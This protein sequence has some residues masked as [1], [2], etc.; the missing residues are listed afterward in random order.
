MAR[1]IGSYSDGQYSIGE[2]DRSAVVRIL[3]LV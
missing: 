2:R 3:C 1:M